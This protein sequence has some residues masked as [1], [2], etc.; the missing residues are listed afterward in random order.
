[1]PTGFRT[2]T[3]LSVTTWW[4]PR[5]SIV[6]PTLTA[7]AVTAGTRLDTYELPDSGVNLDA[8]NTV[9]VSAISDA[10]LTDVPTF[11]KYGGQIH[12]LR[13]IQTTGAVGSD[14]LLAPLSGRPFGFYVRRFGFAPST[15]A[16]ATQVVEAYLVQLGDPQID[17]SS[18]F[19]KIMFP[20]FQQGSFGTSIALT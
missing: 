2:P 5:G 15:A 18:D 7:A 6:L 11:G 9:S 14:D 17:Y 4:V 1:M 13:S 8:P 10:A 19:G 16:A 3:Y 20:A 12:V